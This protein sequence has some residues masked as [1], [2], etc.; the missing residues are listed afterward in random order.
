MRA[1]LF[2]LLLL[3]ALFLSSCLGHS[4]EETRREYTAEIE[5]VIDPECDSTSQIQYWITEVATSD[6]LTGWTANA[7]DSSDIT[8]YYTRTRGCKKYQFH[9]SLKDTAL[10]SKE[11]TMAPWQR[12]FCAH[13]GE[14]SVRIESL[15]YL[16]P[17][18]GSVENSRWVFM[19]LFMSIKI[20]CA[21]LIYATGRFPWKVFPSFIGAFLFSVLLTWH[22]P[23]A[24]IGLFVL[25]SWS[26]GALIFISNRKSISVI[27]TSL[28]VTGSNLAAFG[29]IHLLYSIYY[30]W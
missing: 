23:L 3:T 18:K 27:K 20:L 11:F 21:L 30:L 17:I 19:L 24:A 10:I 14:K 7:L 22:V 1:L 15:D 28:V 13:I 16:F 26:E 4:E 12:N 9:T 2:C 5:I 29:L 6:S 8:S 25:S